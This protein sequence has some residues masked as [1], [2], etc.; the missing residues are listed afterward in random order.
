[1]VPSDEPREQE[2]QDAEVEL[3]AMSVAQAFEASAGAMVYDVHTPQLA[4]AAGL[5]D[6]P[7]FDL[8]SK[9]RSERRG[10]EVK[11]RAGVGD[12]EIS[13]NEWA[14]ACNLRDEYWLYAVFDCGTKQPRLVR[15]QD[16]FGKLL[17]K[18][19]GSMILGAAAILEAAE[20]L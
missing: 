17:A 13:A 8:L 16:P 19:K 1:M 15:V 5:P 4:R 6:N 12:I 11:G 14:K 20:V 10:I 9:R 7:G 18:A 3:V 2:R